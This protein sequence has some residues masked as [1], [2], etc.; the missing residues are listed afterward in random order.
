MTST[1]A[2]FDYI[3]VG[4]GSAGCVLA[5]RLS[6]DPKTSVLLIEAGARDRNPW[7]HVPGGYYKL[8][9][10][11]T[12]SWNFTTSPEPHM[13]NRSMIWPRGRVLG[14]SS[15][16]NAMVYIRG[17][18]QDF[19]MWRQRGCTGWSWS[20]VLPYF[21][22]AEDQARGADDLHGKGGPLGVSD[23]KDHHPLSDAFID[24]A[25]EDGLPRNDDFNGPAQE[26]VGYFQLTMRH[27]RRCST[28][29]G[30]LHP[31]ENRPNL[32]VMTDTLVSRIK[33]EDGRAAGVV[34]RQG[35]Q[36]KRTI[37][38]RREVIL[39]AGAIKS[40]HL[41]LLSGIGPARQ[42]RRFDIPVLHDL[43]GVGQDLQDHL[44]IKMVFEVDKRGRSL[45]RLRRN[46]VLMAQ[47]GLRFLLLRRGPL[48]SGPS[49]AGGFCRSDDALDLPDIQFHFNPVS[50]DK[51]GHFHDFPG[52]SPIVSQLRP[53]SR[54][55]LTLRSPEA[56]EQPAMQA[57]Y[58]AAETDRQVVIKAFRR[59]RRIMARPAMQ[60]YHAREH[61]PGAEA[62][63]DDEL[64]AYAREAGYTQFHPTCTCRMGVDELAVVDPELRV[65][66]IRDLRVV[67]A[68]I[69]PAV[70]SGNTN[71]TTIMIAEKAADLIL[72]RDALAAAA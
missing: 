3:I 10:H 25:V 9:Y 72:G 51:P 50:G 56:K 23:I 57:N 68:S 54:G 14:G 64:I 11:P 34:A 24:A 2:C 36:P 40:P 60:A 41:L 17:Q 28:A 27:T 42:L 21:R 26:G 61:A 22:K 59:V 5:N 53:E 63:S 19:D 31:A 66:G 62:Q 18:A 15:S 32:T 37:K 7:I 39:A 30:Y 47:E 52:C 70:V 12:I 46:P 45:N 13:N 4:A 65:R 38:A 49:M 55:A 8:L 33:L 16:I 44:Q 71:A 43:P 35:T 20:D 67:D 69:M 6:A 1:T 58:L 48:A 29:V